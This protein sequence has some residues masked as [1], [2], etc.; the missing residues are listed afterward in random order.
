MKF[1]KIITLLLTLVVI[2]SLLASCSGGKKENNN[3]NSS[4]QSGNTSGQS[5]DNAS[6]QPQGEP[7]EFRFTLASEPPSL[8]PALS[9]DAQSYIVGLGRLKV[10][11][12]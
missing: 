1:R 12:A 8:D 4:S 9:T 11:I 5:G 2:G 7:K 3:S 10:C 6:Q